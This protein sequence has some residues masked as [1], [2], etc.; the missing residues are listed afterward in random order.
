MSKGRTRAIY[1]TDEEDAIIE[2]YLAG[3]PFPASQALKKIVMNHL[4]GEKYF[5]EVEDFETFFKED[6]PN[7][8]RDD[9]QKNLM[10]IQYMLPHL[11]GSVMEILTKDP[12][13]P[14]KRL[15]AAHQHALKT[16][17]KMGYDVG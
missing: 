8:V 5:E 17:E 7:I 9:T 13:Y 12:S 14:S 4:V 3:Q 1:F 11:F 6:H 15:E 2:E 16:L 10:T